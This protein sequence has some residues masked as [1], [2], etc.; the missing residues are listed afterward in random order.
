MTSA[1]S[2]LF[3]RPVGWRS[4]GWDRPGLPSVP[5]NK[6]CSSIPTFPIH[7]RSYRGTRYPHLRMMP[8][9]IEPAAIRNVNVV[10]CTHRHTDHMDPGTLPLLVA[11]NPDCRFVVPRAE[12]L[13]AQ[14]AGIPAERLVTIDAG[15][16]VALAPDIRITAIPAAHEEL[17]QNAQGE[18]R[19]LG[20]LIEI[21]G[22][23]CYHS[24]DCAPY[25]E[26]LGQL[27]AYAIDMALLPVNGRD[28]ERRS[29]G[30]MGN[31]TCAEAVALCQ[32]ARIP[33]LIPHHFGLFDF[34][35]VSIEEIAA[36]CEVAVN[37]RCIIPRTNTV[38]LVELDGRGA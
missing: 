25:P 10:L 15:E 21:G 32:E 34:N 27:Q 26:L 38:L 6:A 28:V 16:Q 29:H 18:Y 13:A 4:V 23:V 33:A 11:H 14:Q 2:R 3:P 17:E 1:T 20:Y 36:C 7:W 12:I 35:T 9:P 24:G 30:V 5:R 31:F 22:L 19:C 37:V 8:S